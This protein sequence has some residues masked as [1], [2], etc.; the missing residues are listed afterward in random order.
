MSQDK[1]DQNDHIR[2][3]LP[4][5]VEVQPDVLRAQ[6]G[7]MVGHRSAEFR[8]LF[9]RLQPKLRA[10]FQT[11]HRVYVSTS[12]GSGLWEAASRCCVRPGR[13]VLHLVNGAFSARWAEVSQANGKEVDVIEAAWGRAITP[14]QVEEALRARAY[15]AVAATYNETST[16]VLNPLGEIAAVV[17]QHPDTLL[18]ADVVSALAGAPLPTDAWGIDVCLAS[19][20]KAM[21]LP[22]GVAFAAVSDRALARAAEVPHRGYYFDF[23]VLEKYLQRDQTPATPP[24]SLLFAADVQLDAILAEGLEARVARHQAMAQSVQAWA[25]GAGFGLFAEDGYRSPT[26]TT[27]ANTRG[28]DFAALDA[29]LRARGMAISNGYGKLKG[30]TFRIGHMGEVTPADVQ[31]L[32]DAIDAFLAGG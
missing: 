1:P 24:I 12:S 31:T 9:A 15:D 18:L 20:Q 11:Q 6:A 2:L 32:L 26:V 19:S 3:F 5:P 21:A 25:L 27:V 8:A 13:P 22:P 4:G 30:Q 16:G 23:L 17:R 28:I 7:W 14:E 10:L 29:H